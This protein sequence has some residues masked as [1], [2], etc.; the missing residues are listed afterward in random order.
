MAG[1]RDLLNLCVPSG[2]ADT[3]RLAELSSCSPSTIESTFDRIYAAL[4]VS[5]RFDAFAKAIGEGWIRPIPLVGEP[6]SA[7]H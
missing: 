3:R 7:D 2:T 1:Q 5:P 4:G 6:E